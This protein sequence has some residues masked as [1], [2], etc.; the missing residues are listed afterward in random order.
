MS[1][2]FSTN[3]L[4]QILAQRDLPAPRGPIFGSLSPGAPNRLDD[5]QGPSIVQ[6]GLVAAMKVG[7]VVPDW[8]MPTAAWM[9][10]ANNPWDSIAYDRLRHE[11]HWVDYTKYSEH[12]W[13]VDHYP[14][15]KDKGGRNVI[16]NLQ[17]LH[18]HSN[19]VIGALMGAN[20]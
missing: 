1:G 14:I 17:A 20:K 8:L 5:S 16:G 15:A 11:L 3:R 18:S 2:L 9:A 13:Q 4:A 19:A 7:D 10:I 12:G 6:I